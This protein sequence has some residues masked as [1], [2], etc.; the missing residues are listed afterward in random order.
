MKNVKFDTVGQKELA[1]R[2]R[3]AEPQVAAFVDKV[4]ELFGPAEVVYLGPRRVDPT[5]QVAASEREASD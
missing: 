4:R 5:R 3:A 2:N 1:A